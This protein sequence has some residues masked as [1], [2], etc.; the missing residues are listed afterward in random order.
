MQ[1]IIVNVRWLF[2]ASPFQS[3]AVLI[4]FSLQGGLAKLQKIVES[5]EELDA[6]QFTAVLRPFGLSAE[7]LNPKS[8]Q[9]HISPIIERAGKYVREL[10]EDDFKQKV[11]TRNLLCFISSAFS[12]QCGARAGYT[13]TISARRPKP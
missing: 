7:Y 11:L 9:Q 10:K 3:K 2:P 1:Q 8:T 4:G 13:Q 6:A 5:C 12:M